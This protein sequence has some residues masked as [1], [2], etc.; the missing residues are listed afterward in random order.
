MTNAPGCVSVD[1]TIGGAW[2]TSCN[3]TAAHSVQLKRFAAFLGVPAFSGP[4][5]SPLD[6]WSRILRSCIFWSCIFSAPGQICD[7]CQ[8]RSVRCLLSVPRHISKTKQDRPILTTEH[9]LED[10]TADSVAACRSSPVV[11]W[12]RYCGFKCWKICSYI[13]TASCSTSASDHS[14]TVVTPQVLSTE[15]D[16]RNVLITLIVRHVDKWREMTR[17]WNRKRANFLSHWRYSCFCRY[18]LECIDYTRPTGD[19]LTAEAM[20]ESSDMPNTTTDC[21]V[22]DCLTTANFTSSS[23]L[24]SST[25]RASVITSRVVALCVLRWFIWFTQLRWYAYT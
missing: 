13:D 21:A 10:L 23:N 25:S 6:I 22:N 1:H 15:R 24:T 11:P 8:R 16:R 4:T 18:G 5:F 17:K 3:I 7:T 20:K 2:Y 14:A 19:K 9:Y 12:E